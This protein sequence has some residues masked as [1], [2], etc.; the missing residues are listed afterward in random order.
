MKRILLALALLLCLTQLSKDQTVTGPVMCPTRP[1][2]DVSNACASTAFVAQGRG[3]AS[4]GW[5]ILGI[6]TIANNTQGYLVGPGQI[7]L[8]DQDSWLASVSEI[9]TKSVY[10]GNIGQ[11]GPPSAAH[12]LAAIN[13]YAGRGCTAPCV[14]TDGT[15]H[16]VTMN[17]SSPSPVTVTQAAHGYS[18]GKTV[19][20]CTQSS[21]VL[22]VSTLFSTLPAPI[23]E[24]S[25]YFACN[26]TSGNYQLSS[27]YPLAVAGTCDIV[28]TAPGTGNILVNDGD[29]GG[30]DD[31]D[32]AVFV[33]SIS[34][35]AG[36]TLTV[37]S[38]TS[39]TIHVGH[40]LTGIGIAVGTRIT[41]L[42]TGSGGTG[43]YIVS[44]SQTTASTSISAG[45]AI[46]G[47]GYH[48]MVV[49]RYIGAGQPASLQNW[50]AIWTT[51]G[52]T[53][54]PSATAQIA[55]FLFWSCVTWNYT[56]NGGG[57]AAVFDHNIQKLN[58]TWYY[59]SNPPVIATGAQ[60]SISGGGDI[61]WA[62]S[63]IPAGIQPPDTGLIYVTIYNTTPGGMIAL[64][65]N[66][67]FG[68]HNYCAAVGGANNVYQC[69]I[70]PDIG[71][72]GL[73]GTAGATWEF[74]GGVDSY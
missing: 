66:H 6:S 29:M 15:N 39:G 49:S 16:L 22:C 43:T 36:G 35:A 55:G 73:L 46:A 38:V 30:V 7:V 34:T 58:N 52:C 48:L 18:T 53:S 4:C 68:N 8:C 72:I 25:I 17:I 31:Q 63:A 19:N 14:S 20:F 70:I 59:N 71:L 42:G 61:T 44:V 12:N 45:G 26:V 60:G 2:N 62:G 64:A 5:R 41:A 10:L 9:G 37:T 28:T 40:Q 57:N 51:R 13:L 47:I 67:V 50:G 74:V 54:G 24:Q 69:A 1:A 65:P 56:T 33:G 23:L 27:T 32:D 21:G 11:G 3:V